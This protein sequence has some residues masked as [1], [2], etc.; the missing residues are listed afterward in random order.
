MITIKDKAI[1]EG[2]IKIKGFQN[3]VLVFKI[4]NAS[5]VFLIRYFLQKYVF[6]KFFPLNLHQI[7]GKVLLF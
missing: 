3:G 6:I 4:L 7:S 1:K 5:P 2:S